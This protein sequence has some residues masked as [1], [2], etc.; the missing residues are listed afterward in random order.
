[1]LFFIMAIENDN[2]RG[3][4]EKIYELYYGTMLHIA[5]SIL[6]ENHL[7]QDAVSEAFIRIINNLEKINAIDCYQTRGFVVI[8][9]RNISLNMLKHKNRN[10]TTPL[11]DYIE[12]VESEETLFNDDLFDNITI[13]E[14]REEIAAAI[15]KLNKNYSDIL[16]L[17]QEYSMDNA[18]IG[19]IFGLSH[20]NVKTRLSRARKALKQKLLKGEIFYEQQG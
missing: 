12:Y 11:D 10:K 2:D 4:M 17:K 3:K 8:I 6:H 7:A 13:K 5:N 1:M 18:E 14:A 19:K 9:V 15:A 16:F 20:D